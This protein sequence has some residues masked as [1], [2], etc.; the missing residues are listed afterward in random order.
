MT[1]IRTLT[2]LPRDSL[3]RVQ[4]QAINAIG[5]GD[6]SDI[7]TAGA[8]IETEPTNLMVVTID[9]PSTTNTATMVT[10]T[11]LT[12]SS[13]GGANVVITQYEVYWDQ[14]TGNFV[15]LATTSNLYAVQSGLTGGV[16]Y[17]Y[18]VRA[19]NKYGAG[20]FTAPVYMLTSQPPAQPAAPVITVQGQ[21]VKIA[22]TAPFANYQPVLGYQILIQTSTSGQYI[23]DLALCDGGA[24]AVA[25]YCLVDMHDLRKAPFSLTYN[26]LVQA[27][28][29]AQNSRGWSSPSLPNTAGAQIEVEPSAVP[30]PTRG[31]ATGPTQLEVTWSSL[32][33]PNDGSSPVLSYHLQCDYGTNANTWTDVVGLAPDSLL[34]DYIVSTNVVSGVNYGFRV[35]ARNIF[36]WG[37]FSVVTY[38]QAAREPDVPIAPVTTIDAATG[39]VAIA[40]TAPSARGSP[41]TAY[42]I[43]IADVTTTTWQ[44]DPSCDGTQPLIISALLCVVPMSTL[45]AAPY[46]YL[47]DNVVTVRVSAQNFYGFGLVSPNSA[48]TGARIR[49]VPVQM[50]APTPGAASTDV[51]L[52]I[53]WVALSG[54]NAGNSD[55][56]AYD[57][58]WDNG[59]SSGPVTIVLTDALVTTFT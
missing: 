13:T 40:W 22:W 35:R 37:P 45:T 39:G 3:I 11:A 28:V 33:T 5:T 27:M 59:V 2:A 34:T 55:V 48:S 23:E 14:S 47:F 44:T 46:N 12:G 20:L 29:L 25:L 7:N 41:I 43:E 51:A 50:A 54:A 1:I 21:Y 32:V 15:S 24:Q 10:W 38:I 53:N 6:F 16:T 17:A 52:V 19:Y 49:S 42:K 31:A 18:E 30:A 4:V 56:L 9:V 57:L 8:T 58:A 36:G 26:T